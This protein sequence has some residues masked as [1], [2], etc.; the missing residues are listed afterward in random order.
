MSRGS[1][2]SERLERL[3]RLSPEE[4]LR[5]AW[6]H[7]GRRAAITTSF[8]STGCVLIDMASRAGLDLRVVTV[9]T[10]RLHPETYQLMEA[11][12]KRYGLTVERFQPDPEQ[13]RRLVEQ[14]GEYLFFDSKEKQEHCCQVRK[15]AP[16]LRALE[17]LD[18]WITGLRRDQSRHRWGI[19]KASLAQSQGRSLLKLSPLADWTDEQVQRYNAEYQVPCNP[20]Y[21]K[22]YTS[23]GCVICSTPTRPCEHRRAGRWRWF[24]SRHRDDRKECGIHTD[25]SGI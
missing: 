7:Y 17:T 24:N 2:K 11:I 9:D 5:W 13:V 3:T 12:E 1:V 22:G 15:V 20:L 10:L 14:H 23:I 19:P 8:Q 21:E 16:H 4:L 6:R 25:G 18:V